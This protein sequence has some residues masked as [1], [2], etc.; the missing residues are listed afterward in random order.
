MLTALAMC[1]LSAPLRASEVVAPPPQDAS[2]TAGW[3]VEALVV[4]GAGEA[5]DSPALG[6]GPRI[7]GL[8]GVDLVDGDAFEIERVLDFAIVDGGHW[9]S[10][11]VTDDQQ[12]RVVHGE[13][14]TERLSC[15]VAFESALEPVVPGWRPVVVDISLEG[16]RLTLFEDEFAP[17]HRRVVF[18]GEVVA[19]TGVAFEVP[20]P[21][22]ERIGPSYWNTIDDVWVTDDFAVVIAGERQLPPKLPSMSA[23]EA[24]YSIAHVTA[25]QPSMFLGDYALDIALPELPAAPAI[26]MNDL[27]H[28]AWMTSGETSALIVDSVLRVRH[29]ERAPWPFSSYGLGPK[30]PVALNHQLEWAMLTRIDGQGAKRLAIVKNGQAYRLHGKGARF[31]SGQ[32]PAQ[33]V[34]TAPLFLSDNSEVLWMARGATSTALFRDAECVLETG[35]S[36]VDLSFDLFLKELQ[37]S[38]DADLEEALDPPTPE[39]AAQWTLTELDAGPRGLAVTRDGKRALFMG[40]LANGWRGLFL[41]TAP[42][43]E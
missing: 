18:D 30:N 26:V 39:E 17:G 34:A 9:R 31:L 33:L 42:D 27:G 41:A 37:E 35:V 1:L 5:L 40:T 36:G 43:A 3:S 32:A 8:G 19:E 21:G 24:R 22:G 15:V 10:I 6:S 11:V 2:L 13:P 14:Y 16:N 20:G 12:V 29:G 38:L 25:S 28:V 7:D 23:T 4:M